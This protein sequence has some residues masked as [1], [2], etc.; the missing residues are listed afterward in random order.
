MRLFVFFIRAYPGRIAVMLLCLIVAALAEGVG[1]STAL[2]VL[3][4]AF[5]TEAG[6]SPYEAHVRS[7]LDW[8][9]IEAALGPLVLLVAGAFWIKAALILLS[10]RQVGYAVAHVATDLRLSLLR[11]LL[12]AR[13]S[14]YTRQ[15]VGAISNSIATEAERASHAF[16]YLALIFS[17]GIEATLYMSLA[18]AVSWQATLAA[19]FGALISV[20]L[21]SF[22]VRISAR[23]GRK[24]TAI[25]KSLLGRLTDALQATKFLKATGRENAIGPLL[26]DETQRLNRQLQRRVFSREALRALQEP[27]AVSLLCA[28]LYAAV[29]F[30]GMAS[31][32]ILMLAM[33]VFRA[34]SRM[35]SMQQKFQAMVTESSALWSILELRERAEA[36]RESPTGSERANL[37][38]SLALRDVRV[39]FDG[40]TCLDGLC[41]EVPARRITAILGPSGAGK[42]TLVDLLTGLIA[43]DAGQVEVDGVPL[44]E[45]DL[46]DWRR[47]IGYVPQETLLLHDSIRVNISF[48]DPE[49]DDA[50]VQTAL[51]AAGAWEFV[52]QLPDGLESSVGERGSLLSG[53][54]R[55]RIAIAR[56]LV[57]QPD[58]LILDEATAALDTETEVEVWRTIERLRG[59]TTVVAISHQ[60]ALSSVAD[61]IYRLEAGRAR[62]DDQS[63]R[64]V[65]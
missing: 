45:I 59:R 11:A 22:L 60:P 61:R 42:T 25:L 55:Q 5:G 53:G 19:S 14:Y 15:S 37:D 21:L 38:Q 27:F 33:L 2:P 43:P 34:L 54:Q 12:A 41:V 62:R 32:S 56:A 51:Q 30:A 24:Q 4:I 29:H 23:A 20:T 46:A 35:N 8:L 58:L 13:W 65:A 40:R 36:D 6:G 16:Q 44:S 47:R 50:R 10:K 7:L 31:S 57:H 48:G 49:I 17:F 39:D 63:G 9:G 18:L 26:A 52:Q 64:D 3:S 1:L 28:G